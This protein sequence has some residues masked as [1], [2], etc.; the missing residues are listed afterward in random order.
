[1][2]IIKKN[3]GVS[4]DKT[5]SLFGHMKRESRVVNASDGLGF[6]KDSNLKVTSVQKRLERIEG[7]EPCDVIITTYVN[8]KGERTEEAKRLFVLVDD[9]IF[10][11]VNEMLKSYDRV[12]QMK[13]VRKIDPRSF[14]SEL[15]EKFKNDIHFAYKTFYGDFKENTTHSVYIFHLYLIFIATASIIN[16]IDFKPPIHILFEGLRNGISVSISSNVHSELAIKSE[17]QLRALQGVEAKLA[18]I[19]SLCKEE[20]ISSTFQ[21]YKGKIVSEFKIKDVEKEQIRVFSKPDEEDAFFT[22]LTN[23]FTYK[24]K[25]VEEE[26]EDF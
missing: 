1:M 12:R 7:E 19:T 24:G 21:I 15:N 11:S 20:N 25:E 26:A 17:A 13:D 6:L 10:E 16:D 9:E 4:N 2:K 8:E 23:L 3:Q 14:F 18:Y 5:G 22:E